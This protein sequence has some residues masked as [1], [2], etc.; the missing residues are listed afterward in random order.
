MSSFPGLLFGG[1]RANTKI[2][3]GL[4]KLCPIAP[5]FQTSTCRG[6]S[7]G[8]KLS[9]ISVVQAALWHS[10]GRRCQVTENIYHTERQFL[11]NN[12]FGYRP[13]SL[14]DKRKGQSTFSCTSLPCEPVPS[15][16]MTKVILYTQ[17]VGQ[18]ATAPALAQKYK[19]F[20]L[21]SARST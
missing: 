18:L 10:D 17:W 14:L 4:I 1:I 5:Y 12:M 15:S 21:N 8:S 16:L 13:G 20:E 7:P 3:K 2:S 11:S 9:L 6:I 19:H